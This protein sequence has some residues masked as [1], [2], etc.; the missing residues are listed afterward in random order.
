MLGIDGETNIGKI[1]LIVAD[2]KNRG[3]WKREMLYD[4]FEEKM[5]M[6]EDYHCF[7]RDTTLTDRLTS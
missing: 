2:E 7:T 5:E 3:E 1:V 6:S 4:I